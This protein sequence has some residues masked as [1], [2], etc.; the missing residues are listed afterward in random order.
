MPDHEDSLGGETLGGDAKEDRAEQSLGDGHTMG[1][2]TAAHSL[3]DQSTFGDANVDDELFDDGM[4]VVDLTTRY[5]EEDVLG[6]GGF[7]EVMLAT[8]KRLNRKVAIKRIQGKAARSK[9]AVQRFLTEAQSIAT[10]SHNNIV[11]IYDYGRSTDGP[12]LIMEC[13]QGGSLLDLSR[14]G[15]IEL[16]EA[17]KI[18]SQVCDGLAK[19]HTAGIIHRDIKPA[20]IL[21]TEDGVP[22]LTD[23][24][25]AKDDTADAGMTMEGAVIGTLDFMP[26]EQ[27]QGAEFTDHR[28]DLW[29]L[30]ATFYQMLTGKNPKVINIAAIPPK[31]QSVVAKALEE[32]K[33]DRFQSAMEMREAILQAHS[34]KMDTSRSLGEGECPQ[35]ATRNPPDQ[36][37]CRECSGK[38]QVSCLKCKQDM[39]IWDKGCG[40]CGTQQQPLV[41]KKFDQL[42]KKHD[43]AEQFLQELNFEEAETSANAIAAEEDWRLQNFKTWHEEFSQRLVDTRKTEHERLEELLE[44]AKTHEET[45]DYE[46]ARRSLNNVDKRLKDHELEKLG[47]AKSIR[48]RITTVLAKITKLSTANEAV[49]EQ[50]VAFLEEFEFDKAIE[51][52]N[53]IETDDHPH[54]KEDDAWLNEFGEEV[55]SKRN[56]AYK[57]LEEQLSEALDHEENYDYEASRDSLSKVDKRLKD[58]DFENMG[59]VKSIRARITAVLARITKL[60][61]ANDSVKEQAVSLLEEFEFDKAIEAADGIETDDHPHLKEYDVWLYKFRDEV[62]SERNAA[63]KQLEEQLSEALDHEENYDY[64]ASRDSLSKVDK[65]L[66]DVD[67]EN[68]GNAEAIGVR[69]T[70]VLARIKE[71]STANK[72]LK[73]QAVLLLEEFEFDKATEAADGIET[74]DHPHLKEYDVWFY[75]F[76]D[77]VQSKQ[78]VAYKQLEQQLSQALQ[79][80]E[81]FDYEA[82]LESLTHVDSRLFE[83]PQ[84]AMADSSGFFL[85]SARTAK[86][87]SKRISEKIRRADELEK[88]VRDRYRKREF[89][90]LLSIVDELLTL[91]P[92]HTDI[93]KLRAKLVKRETNLLEVRDNAVEQATQQLSGQ[94]F[95]ETLAT[96]NTVSEEVWNGQL[97]EL[98]TKAS[99]LLTELNTLR[100]KIA[101]KVKGNRID[102]ELISDLLRCLTLKA[103]QDDL[104]KLKQDLA[105]RDNQINARNL[106][107]INQTKQYIQHSQFQKATQLLSKIAFDGQSVTIMEL[108][109]QASRFSTKRQKAIQSGTSALEDE[110]FELAIAV[111]NSY[112]IEI[113]SAGIQDQ[114]LLLMIKEA[115]SEHAAAKTYERLIHVGKFFAICLGLCCLPLLLYVIWNAGFSFWT[116]AIWI[117]VCWAVGACVAGTYTPTRFHILLRPLGVAL[118]FFI[119]Y[120]TLEATQHEFGGRLFLIVI[121]FVSWITFLVPDDERQAKL[122]EKWM[123]IVSIFLLGWLCYLTWSVDANPMWGQI[124]LTILFGCGFLINLGLASEQEID[125]DESAA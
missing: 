85:P 76:R 71:L 10:L 30:A 52:A 125:A 68:M 47:S 25:L 23:F 3:G 98:E 105:D 94:Q 55:Q 58:V 83:T 33:E 90:G 12:F 24:G 99:D 78:N 28:S 119:I 72:T 63:Y 36:N 13:V 75:K 18:F 34:G 84:N 8:D 112:L 54:L 100:D 49:K 1:G 113:E 4:E 104:V 51:A 45:C 44:E 11:Q 121:F 17:V 93:Q 118:S 56:S 46:A 82:G 124:L 79:H 114:E 80:E 43:D 103:D 61:M 89:K 7:G 70:T 21:M 5:T 2:D 77:E 73:E 42:Q 67:F 111:F 115:K 86:E 15:P 64:E 81:N 88:T 102:S 39:A 74:D 14:K 19:A 26:P 57:Q 101:E 37:F 96:L 35:C 110:N 41:K 38:L 59:S 66:K 40:E 48:A 29:S 106:K 32:S 53:E 120:Q 69:I 91:N 95:E 62:Q 6:K 9:K 31:L 97:Q 107:I 27:R 123:G 50:A 65:R 60:S 122:L 92:D 117:T 87:I 108:G 109:Q 16:D 20:N 116:S 22:K